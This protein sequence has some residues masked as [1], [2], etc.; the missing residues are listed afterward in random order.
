M[1]SFKLEGQGRYSETIPG[2][3]DPIGSKA[4]QAAAAKDPTLELINQYVNSMTSGG[5]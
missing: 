5:N 1:G 2:T 3:D 4:Y